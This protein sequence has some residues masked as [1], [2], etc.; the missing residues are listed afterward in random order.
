[1]DEWDYL[2]KIESKI[3]KIQNLVYLSLFALCWFYPI[4]SDAFE[5]SSVTVGANPW[6]IGLNPD[7]NM[8]YVTNNGNDT[9]SVVDGSTNMV[10]A[11]VTVGPYP[12]GL[13][14]NPVTNMVYAARFPSSAVSVID[15]S[16]NTVTT[17]VSV[18]KFP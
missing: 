18:G 16:T 6:A 4:T 14:V 5:L 11:N 13:A 3:M 10:S 9:V 1:M 8:I 12:S 17:T 7:T 15:G 2:C